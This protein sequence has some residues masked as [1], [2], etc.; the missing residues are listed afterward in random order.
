MKQ[1]YS[2]TSVLNIS[3]V[4]RIKDSDQWGVLG[5]GHGEFVLGKQTSFLDKIDHP[6]WMAILDADL[7]LIEIRDGGP[8]YKHQL[9]SAEQ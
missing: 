7:R 3:H 6:D 2:P 8:S 9:W 4:F 1:F 5:T